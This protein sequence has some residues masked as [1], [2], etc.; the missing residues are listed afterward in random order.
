MGDTELPLDAVIFATGFNVM[1]GAMDRIDIRGRGN[2]TLKTRWSEGLTSHLGMMT[3]G[4]PNFFWINGPH[5]PFYNP[6]LLAEYQC[7]FICDLI[8]DLKADNTDLIEPL[9]EAEAQYVQLTNDIG[10]ST[11]YPQSDNYYMGDNIEGKPRNT[12][13]WF[14]GFPFYRKQCR[15]ARADWSGFRVE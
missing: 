15:L 8:T 10:N 1:T 13:F 12:L 11:L 2:L 3:E 9:P 4:F 14:G 6:I 5:S 7:D